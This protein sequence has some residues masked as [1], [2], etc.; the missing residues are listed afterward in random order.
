MHGVPGQ[1]ARPLLLTALLALLCAGCMPA[2]AHGPRVEPGFSGGLIG[3][4]SFGPEYIYG[5]MGDL[6]ALV[7]PLGL[8]L[9]YGW[10]PAPP[11]GV[12]AQAT[13]VL[14]LQ[15]DVYV[16]F[17]EA[18]LD[19]LQ[20]GFGA[21]VAIA[22]FTP[23]LQLGRIDDGGSGIYTTQALVLE[24]DE[25]P[26]WLGSLAYQLRKQH[27]TVHL[28]GTGGIDVRPCG[29]NFRCRSAERR[30][31]LVA[32]VALQFH[33]ASSQRS[34]GISRKSSASRIGQ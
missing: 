2:I 4:R 24:V 11:H 15:A 26:M 8:I 34:S 28:F 27:A 16:Q 17:P 20:A 29:E 33:R 6:P 7:P 22:N 3:A 21:T 18:Y 31:L 30:T 10:A 23:Y 5:D 13:L 32:G 1:K 25:P 14:P 19:P 12:A 9:A